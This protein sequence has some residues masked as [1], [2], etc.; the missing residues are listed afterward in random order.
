MLE[1]MTMGVTKS[2]MPL[3]KLPWGPSGLYTRVLLNVSV[4]VL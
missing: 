1:L 3:L 4:V 2:M